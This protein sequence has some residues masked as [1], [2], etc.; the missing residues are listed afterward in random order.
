MCKRDSNP[1]KELKTTQDPKA[2]FFF[3]CRVIQVDSKY[4]CINH[5]LPSFSLI[6]RK[7]DTL[8]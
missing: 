6:I 5:K 8:L 3:Y 4:L 7:S 2:F 1:T